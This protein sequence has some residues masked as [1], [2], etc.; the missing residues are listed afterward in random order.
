MFFGGHSKPFGLA[1]SVRHASVS[2]CWDSLPTPEKIAGSRSRTIRC[3]SEP[4]C[5]VDYKTIKATKSAAA[6][7]ASGVTASGVIQYNPLYKNEKLDKVIDNDDNDD[8]NDNNDTDDV[9]NGTAQ[10]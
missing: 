7:V 9:N 2:W 5:F 6:S 10:Q 1:V 3:K 8:N 4:T